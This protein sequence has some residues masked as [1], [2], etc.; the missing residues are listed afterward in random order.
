MKPTLGV[1]VLLFAWVVIAFILNAIAGFSI[2]NH[3]LFTLQSLQGLGLVISF[4]IQ[5]FIEIFILIIVL[6]LYTIYPNLRLNIA[7]LVLLEGIALL[8]S[9]GAV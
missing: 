3:H 2:L 8:Y 7:I 5:Y 1:A 4:T 9:V 6:I